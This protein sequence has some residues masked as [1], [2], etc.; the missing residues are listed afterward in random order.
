MELRNMEEKPRRGVKPRDII[1]QFRSDTACHP[2]RD[3]E[4]AEQKLREERIAMREEIWKK[5][6]EADAERVRKNKE[7][8]KEILKD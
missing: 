3:I 4:A 2:V 1:N 5:Q 6:Q 8:S 7:S